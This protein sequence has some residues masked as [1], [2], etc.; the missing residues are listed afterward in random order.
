M[1]FTSIYFT[2][3]HYA[4]IHFKAAHSSFFLSLEVGDLWKQKFYQ[5]ATF[6]N[7]KKWIESFRLD[8]KEINLV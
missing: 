7:I 5:N 6:Q 8:F 1:L 3:L 2:L 4:L